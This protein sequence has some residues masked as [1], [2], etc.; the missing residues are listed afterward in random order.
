MLTAELGWL[1]GVVGDLE[2]GVLTWDRELIEATLA[3]F[4]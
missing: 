1:R 3:Q 2:S 4:S